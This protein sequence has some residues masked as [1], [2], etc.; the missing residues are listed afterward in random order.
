MNYL[1][2]GFVAAILGVVPVSAATNAVAP[3]ADAGITSTNS[4]AETELEAIMT[5]DDAAMDEVDGWIRTNSAQATN[6]GG[7]SK[8]ELNQRIKARL[9]GVRQQYGQFLQQYPNDADGHLAYGSFLDNIGNEGLAAAEFQTASQLDP[10]NPAAWNDLANYYGE[11][12]PLTNAFIDYQKAIDLNP[13]EAVYY[14]NL[15]TVVYVYRRDAMAF[16]NLTETQVFDKALSLYRQAVKLDPGNFELGT[17]YAETYYGI[18]PLRI[19]EALEAW[20]NVLKSAQTDVESEGVY[21]H[22]AR[23]KYLGGRYEEARGQL[24]AVT[25]SM[26]AELKNRL[27]RNIT[28]KEHPPTNAA[29]NAVTGTNNPA[30]LSAATN[31]STTASNILIRAMPNPPPFSTKAAGVLPNVPPNPPPPTRLQTTNRPFNPTNLLNS[32]EMT[33]PAPRSPASPP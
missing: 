13:S 16:Y 4:P 25:N 27:E 18:K 1:F 31:Q 19:D 33:P 29:P 12:G 17:D 2:L 23:L 20:T 26:Y 9:D 5:E 28:L 15:A 11:N 30:I 8:D 3:G 6:G 7:L 14:Q 10:K 22:L 24:D 32:F 21:I